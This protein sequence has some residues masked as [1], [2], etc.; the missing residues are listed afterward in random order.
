MSEYTRWYR[1]GTVTGSAGSNAITGKNTYWKT[2]GLNPGDILKLG[3]NDYEVLSVTDDTHLAI[4]GNLSSA[5]NGA[6]YAIV[7]NFTANMSSKIA[8][9]V[10]ELLNDY[11]RYLDTEMATIYGK[12]AYEIAKAHGYTGTETEWL[13]YLIG[14]GKWVELKSQTEASISAQNSNISSQF[15]TQ[16]SR[17]S[18]AESTVSGMSDTVSTLSTRTSFMSSKSMMQRNSFYY[19]G[20]EKKTFT[21]T[22]LANIKA[23]NNNAIFLGTHWKDVPGIWGNIS[24][25]GFNYFLNASNSYGNHAV[26]VATCYTSNFAYNPSSTTI[27]PRYTQSHWYTD[28]R[29]GILS[30]LEDFFG[31][32]NLKTWKATELIF[33]DTTHECTGVATFDGKCELLTMSQVLGWP[34]LFNGKAVIANTYEDL[35]LPLYR[36]LG[37]GTSTGV[38]RD[39]IDWNG[40][41]WGIGEMWGSSDTNAPRLN[42]KNQQNTLG[43]YRVMFVLG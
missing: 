14:A 36:H 13:N 12:S 35:Q 10:S 37:N 43:F 22:D 24:V 32:E 21:D 38:L 42:R 39:A 20:S 31:A 18:T 23:G 25:A 26:L 11:A 30:A 28:I 8:A 15:S 3:G 33:D 1:E 5:F 27:N 16:N 2:A 9:H 34:R 6:S 7:R 19:Y 40:S 4:A 29:P 41:N 17:I